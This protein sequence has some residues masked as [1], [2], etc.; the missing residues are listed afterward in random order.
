MRLLGERRR[1]RSLIPYRED[2]VHHEMRNES[3]IKD[4]NRCFSWSIGQVQVVTLIEFLH[5]ETK[6]TI[7][8]HRLIEMKR[9]GQECIII[10]WFPDHL[11]NGECVIREF[12]DAYSSQQPKGT[13]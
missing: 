12:V 13:F 7:R 2:R 11:S 4:N 10:H 5:L 8:L 9:D 6:I 1:S 3:K